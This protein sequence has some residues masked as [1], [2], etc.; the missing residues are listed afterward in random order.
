MVAFLIGRP[1]NIAG[2]PA[3]ES[4]DA[5]ASSCR[6]KD[7]DP[8]ALGILVTA[9]SLGPNRYSIIFNLAISPPGK[10]EGDLM[11]S[12]AMVR[13]NQEN[14]HVFAAISH[15]SLELLESGVVF[16]SMDI[17]QCPCSTHKCWIGSESIYFCRLVWRFN[18]K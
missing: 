10:H 4:H 12:E 5:G 16:N 13:S 3:A 17:C 7:F 9:G 6:M 11:L 8:R 1:Q 14:G 18:N 2:K 15:R